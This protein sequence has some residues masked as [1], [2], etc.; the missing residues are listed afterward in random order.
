MGFI[1]PVTEVHDKTKG[2]MLYSH[3][4]VSNMIIS[5]ARFTIN[6]H[7]PPALIFSAWLAG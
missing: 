3:W 2:H 7:L 4:N 1:T 5:K 6:L